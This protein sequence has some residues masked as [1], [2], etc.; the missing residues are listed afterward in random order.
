MNSVI[1]VAF[2]LTQIC[3]GPY[4]D[5]IHCGTINTLNIVVV[6][7]AAW[8]VY[9]NSTDVTANDLPIVFNY[10]AIN[11]GPSWNSTVNAA[12][13]PLKGLYYVSVV[14]TTCNK[15]GMQVTLTINDLNRFESKY[16]MNDTNRVQTREQADIF[17]LNVA[18][19]LRVVANNAG[20]IDW[21]YT[22]TDVKL[23]SFAGFL[24]SPGI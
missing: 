19:K 7:Q 9:I 20:H 4:Y 22:G 17:S 8:S 11:V 3:W 5:V 24:L 10:I 23:T 13:A 15:G 12:V 21:G 18:D 6:F 16:P 2:H 14:S 1:S